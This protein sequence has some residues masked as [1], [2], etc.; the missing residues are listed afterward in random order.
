M[1]S[2][3]NDALV[4]RSICADERRHAAL[5]ADVVRWC[6]DQCPILFRGALAAAASRLATST[7]AA[8]SH[9]AFRE[10]TLRSAGLVPGA[11]MRARWSGER[12]TAVEWARDLIA[13]R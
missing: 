12:R 10:E 11:D 2:A 6:L 5:G 3:R 13:S 4:I 9:E 1:T 7:A 8:A